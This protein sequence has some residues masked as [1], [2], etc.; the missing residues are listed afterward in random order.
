MEAKKADLIEQLVES[1][2]EFYRAL[3]PIVPQEWL[4]IDLTMSQ[5]KI[6]LYLATEGPV[7]VSALAS[8]LGVSMA[9]MTGITDRLIQHDYIV[10]YDD[11]ADRRAVICDLSEKGRNVINHMWEIGNLQMKTLLEKLDTRQLETIKEGLDSL[12]KA[13]A[14]LQQSETAAQSL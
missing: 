2:Q 14:E 1:H 11:P 6:A 3:R 12:L 4:N 5:L 9:T 7:R 10:R 13:A 8:F